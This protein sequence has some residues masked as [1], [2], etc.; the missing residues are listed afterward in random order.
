MEYK[1]IIIFNVSF[2]NTCIFLVLRFVL[3]DSIN[4]EVFQMPKDV[5]THTIFNTIQ[6]L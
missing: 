5:E 4:C 3:F 2:E 6:S 1:F